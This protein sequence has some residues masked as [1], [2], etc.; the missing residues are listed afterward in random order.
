MMIINN[1]KNF[2][3]KS[4]ENKY[5][6]IAVVSLNI[7]L[8]IT[9]VALLILDLVDKFNTGVLQ[10]DFDVFSKGTLFTYISAFILTSLVFI[11]LNKKS[12]IDNFYT[13]IVIVM[14]FILITIF[15]LI[16]MAFI[17]IT[18]SGGISITKG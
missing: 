16:C 14:Q 3:K 9:Y 13:T 17:L 5:F 15:L 4:P 10:R 18:S 7:L 12:K 11:Y 8:P 1:L 6:N 2:L